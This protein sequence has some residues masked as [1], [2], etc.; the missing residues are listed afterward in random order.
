MQRIFS[1]EDGLLEMDT[2]LEDEFGDIVLWTRASL[3][4]PSIEQSSSHP[5][6]MDVRIQEMY[7]F[8]SILKLF[9]PQF[10]KDYNG[11]PEIV[12]PT[13]SEEP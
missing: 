2:Y 4:S 12:S 6:S 8:L 10:S 13:P 1:L 7:H 9:N 5:I 11:I 3:L